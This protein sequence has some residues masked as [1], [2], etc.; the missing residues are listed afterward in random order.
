MVMENIEG[1]RVN[2]SHFPHRRPT[3]QY[4]LLHLRAYASVS[5][6]YLAGWGTPFVA[7]YCEEDWDAGGCVLEELCFGVWVMFEDFG[8]VGEDVEGFLDW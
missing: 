2:N 1:R 3:A 5:F 8:R 4:E 7:V 6:T